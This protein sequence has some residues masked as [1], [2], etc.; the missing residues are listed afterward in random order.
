VPEPLLTLNIIKIPFVQDSFELC[1]ID[2]VTPLKHLIN[3]EVF[4]Y[5]DRFKMIIQRVLRI[6][7]NGG[8]VHD[9]L[10]IELLWTAIWD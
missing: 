5:G 9:Q 10:S 6:N 4:G 3:G 2:S 7:C 8:L 1:F